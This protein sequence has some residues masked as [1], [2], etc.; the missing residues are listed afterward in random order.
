MEN[1]FDASAPSPLEDASAARQSS[2]LRPLLEETLQS[3]NRNAGRNV[4]LTLDADRVLAEAE[5]LERNTVG[6]PRPPLYGVPIAIKDCF[7]VAGYTT[8]CGV[9]VFADRNGVAAADSAVAGRLRRQGALVIGKTHL[10]PAA[11]GI[12]VENP[13]Y[14]D[15]L[16]PRD[17]RLLTGGSSS[18]SA[19]SVQEGS[20]LAAIGTDTGGSVRVPAALCGIAGY[21]SSIGLGRGMWEGGVHL[22]A[23]FDTIGWL[24]RDL[25]DGPALGSALFGLVREAPPA[26]ARIAVLPESFLHDCDPSVVDVYRLWKKELERA[27]ARLR[28]FDPDFWADSVEIFAPLQAQEAAALHAGHFH[29]LE[30]TIAE[31]LAWGASFPA[32]ELQ[33]LSRRRAAF[34]ARMDRLLEENDFLIAPC[35]PMSELVAGAD[36]S[37][38][39]KR[40]LRYTTPVSLAGMPAVALPGKGGGVQLAAARGGDALLLAFASRLRPPATPVKSPSEAGT[41]PQ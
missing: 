11:Y 33:S 12:T 7:D 21:R 38:T 24:F 28:D 9:R 35:S 2:P 3:A 15:C 36:H 4:Y 41:R 19:A 22:S 6:G 17:A 8:T 25:R 32:A 23:S 37:A 27:G 18:G 16:Q 40:I 29:E 5:Q 26:E 10:H 14:G 39:R 13:D 20:A 1:G 30:K 34:T 31:R